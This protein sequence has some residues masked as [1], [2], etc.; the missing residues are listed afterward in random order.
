LAPFLLGDLRGQFFGCGVDKPRF[1]ETRFLAAEE[2]LPRIVLRTFF[3]LQGMC[4]QLHHAG[5]G[6]LIFG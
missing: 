6:E 5:S 3:C 4:W 1:P 2:H